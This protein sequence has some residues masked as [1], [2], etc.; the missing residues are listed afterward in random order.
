[1]LKEVLFTKK[2]CSIFKI[3]VIDSDNGFRESFGAAIIDVAFL[4]IL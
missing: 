1:M 2:P 4:G 3:A